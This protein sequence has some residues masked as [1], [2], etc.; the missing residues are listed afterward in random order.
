MDLNCH[1]GRQ[2]WIH[3]EKSMTEG[4]ERVKIANL[5]K[6]NT[7]VHR[8]TNELFTDETNHKEVIFGNTRTTI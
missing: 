6:Y 1:I 4:F 3:P 8:V 7:E 2:R 5:I